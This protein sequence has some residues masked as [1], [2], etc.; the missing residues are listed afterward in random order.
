M[1]IP[2]HLATVM[3]VTIAAGS[4]SF[5]VANADTK[6]SNEQIIGKNRFETAVKISQKGWKTAES[7]I[8]VNDS[9]IADALSA[10]PFA[11][12]KNAPVLLT[13]KNN[14]HSST[15][16]ELKRLG[17]KNIY[18]IGGS[19]VL[20]ENV[21][22]ELE[23]AGMKVERIAGSTREATSVEIAEKLDSIKNVKEIAVVNGTTGLS[24]AVSVAAAAADKDMPIILSNPK[25]GTEAADKFIKDNGITKSYI[26]G[27]TK[28]I[29]STVASKLPGATRLQGDNRNDTNAK[30]METFYTSRDISNVY[31]AK[32]GKGEETNIIDALSVGVLAAKNDVPVMIVDSK[33]LS[34][35]QKNVI[36][37]K[38]FAKITQVGGQGNEKAFSE[39]NKIQAVTTY[40][41]STVAE[42]NNALSKADANDVINMN[43]SSARMSARAISENI[44]ISTN[45]AISIKLS[46]TY[47]GKITLKIANAKVI[48]NGTIK[49]LSVESTK[50]ATVENTASAKIEKVTVSSTSSNVEIINKGTVSKVEN[51]ATGTTINNQGTISSPVTGSVSPEIS[52]NKPSDSTNNGGT[53]NGGGSSSGGSSSGGVTDESTE[54]VTD[55]SVPSYDNLAWAENEYKKANAWCLPN[56]NEQKEG[57]FLIATEK[58]TSD[59]EYQGKSALID[60]GTK[61]AWEISTLA[62]LKVSHKDGMNETPIPG[63]LDKSN[64]CGKMTKFDMTL[65]NGKILSVGFGDPN[66]DGTNGWYYKISPAAAILGTDG[67]ADPGW[68]KIENI[69]AP[70]ENAEV[71]IDIKYESG[72]LTLTIGG[73]AKEIAE[74]ELAGKT[75]VTKIGFANRDNV[76]GEYISVWKMPTIKTSEK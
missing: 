69:S 34:D 56:P 54:L 35:G 57:L 75:G 76:D 60:M 8:L 28:A 52:G 6:S 3:A 36:N 9:A 59:G 24:D 64:N 63:M 13:G 5:N 58:G 31:V 74:T 15:M 30:V 66:V 65:S 1:R 47:T 41:V 7:A 49:E 44:T 62:D 14:V 68:T 55:I 50:N 27:G 48:N 42:L 12:A 73:T 38:S 53:S 16:A 25:K 11:D 32:D 29:S 4:L 72:K 18:L 70:T 61:N 40:N 33:K 37:T 17:V 20:S 22:S 67:V 39:L 26:I 71:K 23:K 10:T 21:K 45:K 19:A 43:E 46:G 2:K 51:N